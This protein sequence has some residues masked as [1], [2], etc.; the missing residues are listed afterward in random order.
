MN[1]ELKPCPFCGGKAKLVIKGRTY[2]KNIQDHIIYCICLKCGGTGQVFKIEDFDDS[3]K[4]LD[5]ARNAW[6]R[7]TN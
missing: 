6:N 5:R 2:V 4:A 3:R 7:R 1:T